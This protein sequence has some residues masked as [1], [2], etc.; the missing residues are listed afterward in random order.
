MQQGIRILLFLKCPLLPAIRAKLRYRLSF[1]L[2][3]ILAIPAHEFHI[4]L[5]RKEEYKN[6]SEV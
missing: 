5:L 3:P 1:R 2:K 4:L 6:L